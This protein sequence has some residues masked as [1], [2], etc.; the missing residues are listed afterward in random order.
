MKGLPSTWDVHGYSLPYTVLCF[1]C[2]KRIFFLTKISCRHLKLRRFNVKN[3]ISISFEKLEGL[4][5][6]CL[7]FHRVIAG[8]AKSPW[9]K[10]TAGP[11]SQIPREAVCPSPQS[12]LLPIVS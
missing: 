2:R 6:W 4:A 3:Y 11:E 7:P 12:S 10:V 1:A 9:G 5:T 8:G